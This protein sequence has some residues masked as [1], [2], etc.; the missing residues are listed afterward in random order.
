MLMFK[1]QTED[2]TGGMRETEEIGLVWGES[3]KCRATARKHE[4]L[5]KKDVIRRMQSSRE[6]DTVSLVGWK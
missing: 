1:A 4:E 5:Q 3:G 2:G 6:M